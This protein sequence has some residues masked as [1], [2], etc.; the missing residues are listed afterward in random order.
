M[1]INEKEFVQLRNLVYSLNEKVK[2]IKKKKF[3]LLNKRDSSPLTEA[4]MYVN[5]KLNEFVN[6][7]N[8][9]NVISEENK[10]FEYKERK[11]WDWFW[12]IDPIDGT[13]EFVE[14]RK[15]YTINIA[16]CFDKRP[17]FGLISVPETNDIY[18]AFKGMGAFKN[19][20]RLLLKSTETNEEINIVASKSHLND[21]TTNYINNLKKK[22]KVNLLQFGSSLKICKVA[23]GV[24]DIYPRFGPTMEWDTC[25]ADIIINEANGKMLDLKKNKLSYNKENLL[26]PHFIVARSTIG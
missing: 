6:S 14:K 10:N 23:E 13:K 3:K 26:N 20:K 18:Y 4:D 2:S 24:A 9:R 25:A 11:K 1:T 17:I 21:E 8:Y 16:L 7:T 12:V 19:D 5:E 15:D 22:K